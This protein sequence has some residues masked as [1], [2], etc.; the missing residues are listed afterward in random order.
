MTVTMLFG[1]LLVSALL[2]VCVRQFYPP[3]LN[4]SDDSGAQAVVV[5]GGGINQSPS[6]CRPSAASM[7]RL[8]AALDEVEQ[9]KL[10]LLISGGGNRGKECDSEA[11]LMADSL[12]H[13]QVEA[14][15]LEGDSQNTY[16]NALYSSEL[17]KQK[18]IAKVVLVTDMEHMPRAV[19]CFRKF[20]IEV[21]P[22]P[23]DRLPEPVWM[24]TSAA[25]MVLP[26]IWYEWLA[27]LWY[28]LKY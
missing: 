11:Q 1:L 3:I 5:L 15:W 14:L 4:A 6:G 16:A 27:L 19:R 23:I 8:L 13:G 17:L 2:P 12:A 9:R 24:P 25:A 18:R 20:N 21:I 26:A 7:R 22:A 10:P 28:E